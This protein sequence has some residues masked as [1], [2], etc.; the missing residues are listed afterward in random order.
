MVEKFSTY[1]FVESRTGLIG[2]FL[3]PSSD[4]VT[5]VRVSS[6]YDEKGKNADTPSPSNRLF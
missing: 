2:T 5:R 1:S 6:A 3:L 4:A